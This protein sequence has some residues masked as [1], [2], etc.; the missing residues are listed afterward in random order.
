V[1]VRIRRAALHGALAL[2]ATIS[3]GPFL[4]L[5]CA[6]FKRD[7]DIFRYLLLPWREPSR[8]TL[9]NFSALWRR[10]P[11]FDWLC[12]SLFLACAQ[13]CIV[14]VLSSMAG[15]ALAKYR[16]RFRR[17][18]IGVLLASML[19]PYQVLLPSLR[20]MM[21]QLGW[22]NSYAA[23]LLPSSVSAFGAL[24]FMQAMWQVPDELLQAARIDGCSEWRLWWEIA[25]P[26]V[27][28]MLGA[29]TLLSFMASWNSYLWPQIVLQS[30]QKYT[31]PI[32]LANMMAMGEQQIPYGP[33]MAGTLLSILPVAALFFVLQRDF[34]AGLASGSIKG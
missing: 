26:M 18:L 19:L 14:V 3:L 28:P 9:G 1:T 32:G 24:L 2:M 12:N 10:Y 7:D 27:R 23:I 30:E 4:W 31:L 13:T 21:H 25:L 22:I 20:L 11:F 5:V 15:F 34:I 17:L 8:W 33:L 6:S 16:F 29:Y